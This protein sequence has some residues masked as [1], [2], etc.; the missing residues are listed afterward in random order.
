[1]A[2]ALSD[3]AGHSLWETDNRKFE[4]QVENV[5]RALRADAGA[6]EKPTLPKL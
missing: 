5:I 3:L 1:L 2:D 6:R 4:M